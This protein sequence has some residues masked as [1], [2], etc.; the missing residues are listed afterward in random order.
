MT[1]RRLPAGRTAGFQPAVPA[2]RPGE[3]RRLEDSGTAGRMPALHRNLR[4]SLRALFSHRVRAVLALSSVAIGVAAVVLISAIGAGAQQEVARKIETVGTNLLIVRP[5]QVERLASR[6]TIRGSVSTLTLD[7]AAAIAELP[8][9]ALAGPGAERNA[10]VKSGSF[11]TVTKILGTTPAF[12]TIR[13]FRVRQGVFFDADDDRNARRVVVLGSRIGEHVPVGSELRIRGIPFEVI[14]ILEEKGVSADGSDEDN[15]VLIPIRTAMRRVFN[16]T[17]LT[18]VFI[19]ASSDIAVTQENVA[20]LL[21]ARHR[22]EDFGVQNTTRFLS[23]QKQTAD[24]LTTLGT[25]LGGVALVVGGTG[26][27]A[28]MM[29]SV[30]ERTAEIGLR[31][32]VGATPRDILLQFLFEATLLSVGGWMIGLALGALG[33]VVVALGAEW[34]LALPGGALLATIAMVL[35]CGLGFGSIPA[36]KA[37]LLPPIEALLAH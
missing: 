14:G 1:E 15:Q 17:W 22:R 37:S 16:T 8:N 4:L 26:I 9:V 7:D 34:T 28:L 5:A 32:A 18:T 3:T 2:R 33:A 19:R 27:L 23:M 31:M 24:F 25:A 29:T 12:L 6:K 11:V 35:I 20:A 30:R 36:R 21:R 13:A 10:R